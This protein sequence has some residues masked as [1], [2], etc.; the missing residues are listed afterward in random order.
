[1]NDQLWCSSKENKFECV[2]PYGEAT[3]QIGKSVIR[4]LLIKA[5]P[6]YLHVS[7]FTREQRQEFQ[8]IQTPL[9][10]LFFYLSLCNLQN[11]NLR[12]YIYFYPRISR[13]SGLKTIGS[14]R[15]GHGNANIVRNH[16]VEWFESKHY[17]LRGDIR[18]W[19]MQLS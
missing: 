1:M 3:R 4:Q 11:E 15:E 14:E 13:C 12:K 9:S 18:T 2:N 6:F 16:V 17:K 10:I 5:F 19:L 7:Y 8:C